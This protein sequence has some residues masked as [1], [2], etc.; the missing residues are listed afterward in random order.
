MGPL[1]SS[2][3]PSCTV[4]AHMALLS[5]LAVTPHWSQWEVGEKAKAP[6]GAHSSVGEDNT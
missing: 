2:P 5:R 4:P 1:A 6:L 3:H